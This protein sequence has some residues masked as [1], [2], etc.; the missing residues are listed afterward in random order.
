MGRQPGQSDGNGTRTGRVKTARQ[1]GRLSIDRSLAVMDLVGLIFEAALDPASWPAALDRLALATGSRYAS[2]GTF[3]LVTRQ[4]AAAAVGY[5]PEYLRR[6]TEEGWAT[7]N[8]HWQRSGFTPVGQV[9]SP[10]MFVPRDEFVRTDFYNEWAAPLGHENALGV[11][12]LIEGANSTSAAVTRPFSKDIYS[13]EEQRLFAALVPHIQRAVQLQHRLAALEMH[14][15]SSVEGF[16]RLSD[17]VVI[18]DDEFAILFANRAAEALLAERDGVRVDSDGIAGG[19][20]A[21]TDT[22]RGLLAAR[23]INGTPGAG[24]RCQLTRREG[25]SPLSALVVPLRNGADWPVLLRRHANLVFLTDPDHE[26]RARFTALRGQFGL[27]R[28]ESAFL[29]EI[30]KGD[31]LQAAA[32]RLGVSLATA[33]THLRHVF[34]KTGTRRQAELVKL[35]ATGPGTLRDDC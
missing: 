9:F 2:L 15:A 30:V 32:D 24:G 23:A 16:N 26:A 5:D 35:A 33:R 17:G 20:Q 8:I 21:D 31:G 25:R 11:N 4:V 13:P 10:E 19:T 18:V 12:V 28:A 22:L 6:Y 34:D 3:N 14:R 29:A 1:T 27:T 7:K